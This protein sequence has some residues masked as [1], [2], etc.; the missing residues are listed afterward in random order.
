MK[1]SIGR[2]NRVKRVIGTVIATLVVGLIA[3]VNGPAPAAARVQAAT[4]TPTLSSW[5]ECPDLGDLECSTLT[6]PLDYDNPD[7]GKTVKLRVS[8][9]KASPSAGSYLGALV[10]NP[11]GPGGSGT[12]TPLLRGSVPGTVA[13]RYDWVGFDPR[14]VGASTPTLH[15]NTKY[16][17]P[18]RPNYVPRTKALRKYWLTKTAGYAKACSTS[19][20]KGLLPF[21]TTKDSALDVE[22]LRT[23]LQAAA[24]LGQQS[25]L[26]KLNYYGFSY[27]TYLGAV[28]ATLFPAKVGR[29][30]LDGVVD[31][32]RFWYASNLDQDVAFDKN[33]NRFFTWV[34]RHNGKFHLGTKPAKIRAGYNALLTKLDRKP[35]AG[36]KLGP[37]ELADAILGVGYGV[38]DWAGVATDYSRLRR[39]GRG[40]PMYARYASSVLGSEAENN[41]A[42][43]LGV[44]CTDQRSPGWSKFASDTWRIHKKRPF[45]AWNNAWY[46]MPCRTWSAAA[47][48]RVNVTGSALTALGTKVLL[49]NE[50]YD[51]AT[52]FSGA[53]SLRS[54][55]PTASLIEGYRGTTHSASLSGIAC[56]DNRIASYLATGTVPT[57][58]SGNRSDVRCPAVPRPSAGR[59]AARATAES[60]SL[61]D[62]LAAAQRASFR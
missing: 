17:G 45:L 6:V 9:L 8:R 54:L 22:S 61:R 59:T 35:A 32:K 15:C 53:L 7:N 33:L 37:D 48:D 46:N 2:G 44:Q 14:G 30:V 49:I 12:W 42:V 56:V 41:Y 11:G 28:Y 19:A 21:M 26:A 18:N 57:R 55:F 52:P 10:L 4:F 13:L 40:Y 50:T 16:F 43:Y 34:A 36:G 1:R 24:P 47:H 62:L 60:A 20:A 58:L 51:A 5:Q 31:P 23:A 27:G 3:T 29:F 39:F 25:K 38:Y